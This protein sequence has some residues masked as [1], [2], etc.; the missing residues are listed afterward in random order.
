MCDRSGDHTRDDS[1]LRR[2]LGCGWLSHKISRGK[3][4]R[5][6]GGPGLGGEG[7]DP[8]VSLPSISRFSVGKPFWFPRG[9]GQPL[10]G[11]PPWNRWLAS[12][13]ESRCG[14]VRRSA[15]G[16][17]HEAPKL[18]TV[19]G[20]GCRRASCSYPTWKKFCSGSGSATRLAPR[21][22]SSGPRSL[23]SKPVSHRPSRGNA[24][25]RRPIISNSRLATK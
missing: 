20:I 10:D 23:R 8:Q 21:R 5:C 2:G 22:T 19:W 4:A 14:S 6:R 24:G 13:E 9:L 3:R 15:H 16:N 1:R 12:C 17:R 25:S 7:T 18:E 11:I